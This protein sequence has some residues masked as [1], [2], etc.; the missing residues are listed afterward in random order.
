MRDKRRNTEGSPPELISDPDQKARAEARN[1]VR[2]LDKAHE[3]ISAFLDPGYDRPFRLTQDMILELNYLAIEGIETFAGTYRNGEVEINASEHKPPSPFRVA[4]LVVEMCDYV[5]ENFDSKEALHLA[6]YIMWRLNW[7]HP[8]FDA[9][10]R[11]SR[12]VSYLVMCIKLRILLPGTKTMP[13]I[14]SENREPYY[15][16]LEFADQKSDER[17][18][19]V[20]DMESLLS[21]LLVGQLLSAH[22]EAQGLIPKRRGLSRKQR[23]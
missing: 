2:Q 11:T 4:S 12:V 14:I 1:G 23:V 21:K 20:S 17:T 5:N 15:R 9:N 13:E 8:F 6:A 10:G 22:P 3:W 19:D 16:A 18:V 7:I